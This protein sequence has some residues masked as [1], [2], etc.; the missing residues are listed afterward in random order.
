MWSELHAATRTSATSGNWSDPATWATGLPQTGDDV[1]IENGDTVTIDVALLQLRSI[2]IRRG[3]LIAGTARIELSER[4][5]GPGTFVEGTSTV[6]YVND[7]PLEITAVFISNYYHLTLADSLRAYGSRTLS[8][9]LTVSG[10]F[11]CDLRRS[12]SL[13]L[14]GAGSLRVGGNFIYVGQSTTEWTGSILLSGT[15]A[16]KES[17]LIVT[18][19][20]QRPASGSFVFPRIMIRKNDTTQIVRVGKDIRSLKP[21]HEDTLYVSSV[22]DSQ[23][24]VESG[25]FDV[26]RGIVRSTDRQPDILLNPGTRFRTGVT[27]DPDTLVCARVLLDSGSTY[28]YYTNGIKD[29][30]YGL[31]FIESRRYHHLWLSAPVV[32][33]FSHSDIEI[34][35]NLYIQNGAEINPKAG[36]GTYRKASITVRGDVVNESRGHSGAVGNGFGGGDGMTPHDEMW[37]FDRPGDTIKWSGP[38]ELRALRVTDGTVLSVRYTSHEQ[39]DS[40]L[41]R[42]SITEEGGVCGAHVIGKIFTTP[43]RFWAGDDRMHRFGNIGLEITSGTEPYLELTRVVRI[44]GYDPPGER[45]GIQPERTVKRYFAIT[46]STGA[47]RGERNTMKFSLHCDELNGANPGELSFW[48]STN[49]GGAWRLSGL[50]SFDEAQLTARWDTTVLGFP[51]NTNLW[52]YRQYLWTLSTQQDDLALPVTLESFSLRPTSF[53]A[54][55]KWRTS[56]E[57]ETR[58]FAIDREVG[59]IA[60]RIASYASHPELR[61]RSLY[62]DE[63]QYHDSLDH[64]GVIRYTLYE[65][66]RDGSE[67]R[68]ASEQVE[69]QRN[70]GAGITQQGAKLTIEK[71]G[72]SEDSRV[73]IEIS[74]ITGRRLMRQQLVNPSQNRWEFQVPPSI[75]GPVFIRVY[76]ESWEYHGKLLIWSD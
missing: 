72:A 6:A 26:M 57:I 23:V 2:E 76:S 59:S 64:D 30:S 27:G 75:R 17:Y 8:Q 45:I 43:Y 49:S 5:L 74:D 29:I 18:T 33:G 10:N 67:M 21:L 19:P 40:L 32:A 53:G 41:F 65:V 4:L 42:D 3:F 58:G 51:D 46:Q 63:Y 22:I 71:P 54:R 28:E 66:S 73:L 60:E 25:S 34:A 48:R 13:S 62:G 20:L 61:G 7:Q 36:S 35:G 1:I 52:T 15:P 9:D 37:I 24:V 55:L 47:Q 69:L 56:Q 14:S 31:K 12:D 44:A 38:G 39:C 50:T 11:E 16:I 70:V 68:L